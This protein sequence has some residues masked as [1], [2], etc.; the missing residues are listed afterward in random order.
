MLAIESNFTADVSNS[1]L[2][3]QYLPFR[4]GYYTFDGVILYRNRVVEATSLRSIALKTLHAAHQ[5]VSAM[6]RC[7]RAT[8]FWPGMTEDINTTRNSFVHC[9]RNA[10]SQA[11]VHRCLSTCLPHP[12]STFLLT[13]L[14]TVGATFW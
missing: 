7:A 3:R 8:V 1:P 10:P 6:E 12:S 14:I 5:G 9:N 2:I 13:F 4:D 11:A